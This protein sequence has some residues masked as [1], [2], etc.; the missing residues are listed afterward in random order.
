VAEEFDFSELAGMV[1]AIALTDAASLKEAL[2]IAYVLDRAGIAVNQEGSGLTFFCPFHEDRNTPAGAVYGE[3]LMRWN[4]WACGA[5]RQG[6]VLDLIQQLAEL[7]GETLEFVQVCD[8]A[9][10]YVIEMEA[11]N[12]EG[13]RSAAPRKS[14]DSDTVIKIVERAQAND[15]YSLIDDLLATKRERD[16]EDSNRYSV[17]FLVDEFG[18]GVTEVFAKDINAWRSEVIIP[19]RNAAGELTTYKHRL[20]NTKAK[21]PSGAWP[22]DTPF[23]NAWRIDNLD[24]RIFIC[25]GESDVWNAQY[26]IGNSY[27][28]LG[29]PNGASTPSRNVEAFKGKDVLLAFDGDD[30]GRKG[31]ARWAEALKRAGAN[32]LIVPIP[33]GKDVSGVAASLKSLVASAR[34]IVMSPTGLRATDNGYVRS[35]ASGDTQVSNFTLEPLREL[36]GDNTTAFEVRVL[37]GGNISIIEDKDLSNKGAM[38]KWTLANKRAW[39]GSDRDVNILLGTLQAQCVYL[40]IGRLTKV[41]GLHDSHFVW[42]GGHIGP[43]PWRYVSS[44]AN[45]EDSMDIRHGTWSP[46][47]IHILRSIH[48]RKVIDPILAWLMAAPGRSLHKEFPILAISGPH[49]S[50]KTRTLETLLRAMTGT[51]IAKTLTGT[52]PFAVLSSFASTNGFPV[53]FEE[54]RMGAR[55][56]A[57]AIFEQ[58]AR[59][60]YT[61]QASEKGGMKGNWADITSI[62]PTAPV[63]VSGEDMF[64]EGSHIERM[65][66]LQMY[67]DGQNPKAFKEANSWKHNGLPYAILTWW[68]RSLYDGTLRDFTIAPAEYDD[69]GP[70]QN[71]NIGILLHGWKLLQQFMFES[72]D[73]LDDMDLSMVLSELQDA[74]VHTPIEDA[75][76]W[77]LEESDAFSFVQLHNDELY[78]RVENFVSFI[79]EKKRRGDL[80]FTLPGRAPSIKKYLKSKFSATEEVKRSGNL[81]QTW[82]KF[83]YNKMI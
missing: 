17:E 31:S 73:S 45:L 4:C 20:A 3:G 80:S 79:N 18:L 74:N 78:V 32:V 70:R 48:E 62:I 68:H 25:E 38:V 77:C 2:P 40:P 60:A 52:T 37:P 50:G 65:I 14:V 71:M 35:N 72:D 6:D 30:A 26:E 28:V 1:D 66:L 57:K 51:Y 83:D 24:L 76:R 42:P 67:R 69:L 13:P 21:A 22:T 15:D 34:P 63:I 39:Y 59:D 8:R 9:R 33:E 55:D 12:W 19:Y 46:E 61:M 44:G 56:D 23:Y 7:D 47:Y 81:V 27:R 75:L 64:S 10:S 53:V 82:L 54:Y 5:P 29:I 58:L 41:A 49:G 43:E 36:V 11:S 16:G